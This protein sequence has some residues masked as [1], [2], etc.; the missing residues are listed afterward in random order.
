[1]SATDTFR[2]FEDNADSQEDDKVSGMLVNV[3]GLQLPN[4]MFSAAARSAL[5][6]AQRLQE[7]AKAVEKPQKP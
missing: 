3:F 6:L 4:E 1:M 5:E 7:Y 2:V